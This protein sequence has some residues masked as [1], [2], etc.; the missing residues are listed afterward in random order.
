MKAVAYTRY[1]SDMQTPD[2]T[3]AQIR[4]IKKYA[5][6][7]GIDIVDIYSDEETTGKNDQRP[8]FLR[9]MAELKTKGVQMVLLHKIDRFARNKYDSVIH[10][11]KIRALGIQIQYAAQ[12]IANSKEGRLMEGMLEDFAQYFSDNLGRRNHE[13]PERKRL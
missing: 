6:D 1:S 8:E 5:A 4:A 2:S 7:N 12:P 13:G 10:K 9:M 11:R 3:A